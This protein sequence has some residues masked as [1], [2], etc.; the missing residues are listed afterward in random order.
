MAS[1][2][3]IR[4]RRPAAAERL[5]AHHGSGRLVIDIKIP[6]GMAQ[7]ILCRLDGFL[8]PAKMEPV[9]P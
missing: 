1:C 6:G 2:L 9:N 7:P 8:S 5:Q 3:V 4:P